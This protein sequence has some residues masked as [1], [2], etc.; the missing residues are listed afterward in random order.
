[1]VVVW[2]LQLTANS[3]GVALALQMCF[4]TYGLPGAIYFDNGKEFKNY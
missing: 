1:M 2:S 4:D 3:T